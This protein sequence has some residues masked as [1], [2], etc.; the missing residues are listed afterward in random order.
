MGEKVRES[1]AFDGEINKK[2]AVLFAK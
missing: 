2:G 1:T